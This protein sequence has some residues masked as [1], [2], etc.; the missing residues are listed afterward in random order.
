MF[1]PYST[2]ILRTYYGS[3][4]WVDCAF[5]VTIIYEHSMLGWLIDMD[6]VLWTGPSGCTSGNK[7]Q[8]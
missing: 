8:G 3:S 2:E 4:F 7:R 1:F 5:L 6:G